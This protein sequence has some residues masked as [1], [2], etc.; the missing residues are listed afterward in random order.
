MISNPGGS[1]IRKKR[2]NVKFEEK[3]KNSTIEETPVPDGEEAGLKE[4]EELIRSQRKS[5]SYKS[6]STIHI[7]ICLLVLNFNIDLF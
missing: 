7:G 6:Y 3:E 2:R 5:S 1:K 4:F